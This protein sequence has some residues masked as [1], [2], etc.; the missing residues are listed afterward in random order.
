[1]QLFLLDSFE[2]KHYRDSKKI[3]SRNRDGIFFYI[4]K[5][6]QLIQENQIIIREI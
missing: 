4:S 3:P 6:K 2:P 5:P 1:M